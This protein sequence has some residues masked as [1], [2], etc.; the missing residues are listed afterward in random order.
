MLE[1]CYA[2]S[3]R[4]RLDSTGGTYRLRC[5]HPLQ[6]ITLN[7]SAWRLL[8]ALQPGVPLDTLA[9]GAGADVVAF[10][11]GLVLRGAL[12][13]EYRLL[14]AHDPAPVDV[15]V[16]A[17][18]DPAPLRRCLE[19]LAAQHY[20][21]GHVRVTVVDDAS[22]QALQA[23]VGALPEGLMLR[24]LRLPHNVG[25]ASARNAGVLTPWPEEA[26]TPGSPT[27]RSWLAFVDADCVPVQDW[28]AGLAAL[29][30]DPLV[31]A[32]GGAV[33]GLTRQGLLGR[34]EDACSSLYLG[35]RPGPV[36]LPDGALAY[37]PSCNLA[38][39]RDAFQQVGGFREGWRF[40]E[41][42]DLCWRLYAAGHSL[43]YHP[44]PAVAHEHRTRWGAFL[45]RR[46]MYGR[47]EAALR[48]AHPGRFG[49]LLQPGPMVALA[50]AVLALWSRRPAAWGL[51]AA[52]LLGLAGLPLLRRLRAGADEAAWP[53]RMLIGAGVR[54]GAAQLV[55]QARRLNRQ[56]LV[57]WLPV[58]AL[59]PALLPLGAV[60]FALG[61]L[62]EWLARRPALGPGSYLAGYAGECLAYS[63]GRVEGLVLQTWHRMR[64]R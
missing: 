56:L 17:F 27:S 21:A 20:P 26:S 43:F 34:Y 7:E 28:L 63:L 24:W 32:A 51:V 55:Q 2:L 54:R 22:P 3:P 38:V 13:A 36:A 1:R 29:L 59:V 25:P 44:A 62:G 40:G 46:R 8:A 49:S 4:S 19:A 11:D 48:R 47:S 30:E 15:V 6:T 60:V 35:E 45:Q 58:L 10:L 53:L 42:V 5:E 50:A 31:A 9:A 57:A 41:D 64:G 14:P 52:A 33:R 16:P 39:R 37:L 12:Q 23:A 18:G 61:A